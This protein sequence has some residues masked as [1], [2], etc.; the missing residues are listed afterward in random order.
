LLN[1]TKVLFLWQTDFLTGTRLSYLL[2]C[3]NDA[4]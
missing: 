2:T 3:A 1:D 4:P